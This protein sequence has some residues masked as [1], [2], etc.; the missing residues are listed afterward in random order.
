MVPD[1]LTSCGP[2][3]PVDSEHIRL[4]K[5]S[6][7]MMRVIRE[8]SISAAAADTGH[9]TVGIIALDV[10][11]NVASGTSTNG[12]RFRIPGFVIT[13]LF[14]IDFCLSVCLF[15]CPNTSAP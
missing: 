6:N 9:D 5:V 1:P 10:Q 14:C 12:A 2:Y 3:R 4:L 13:A 7:E 8:P 15:V 11:A